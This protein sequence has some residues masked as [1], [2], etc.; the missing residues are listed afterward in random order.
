V[1]RGILGAFDRRRYVL[2]LLKPGTRVLDVGCGA[3][4]FV[5]VLRAMSV[6][7][8]GIEPDAAFG[9]FA[10]EVLELPVQIGVVTK[11]AFP[12][13]S[14]DVITMFHALEHTADPIETLAIAASWLKASGTLL[15]EVPNVNARCQAPEHRF[16]YAHLFSFSPGTLNAAAAKAGLVPT[17]M[18]LSEDEGNI[19]AFFGKGQPPSMVSVD[20]NSYDQTRGVLRTHTAVRHYFSPI[21]Y[22]RALERLR[23]RR[24]ENRLLRRLKTMDQILGL[25]AQ[26][27]LKD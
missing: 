16:H 21:P 25:A 19:I 5:Y 7:A 11:D 12:S 27:G 4:E 9:H 24:R 2:S 22:M 20:S 6:D 8:A 1:L 10:R 3:G 14:F 23:K 26:G 15:V 18:E 17:R 13:A